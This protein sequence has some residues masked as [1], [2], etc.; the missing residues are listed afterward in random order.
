MTSTDDLPATGVLRSTLSSRNLPIWGSRAQMYERLKKGHETTKL[1]SK[2]G[3]TTTLTSDTTN[4]S[5]VPKPAFEP[6]ERTFY[7]QERPKLLARGITDHVALVA[8]LKRLWVAK[9]TSNPRSKKQP[10]HHRKQISKA[11]AKETSTRMFKSFVCMSGVDMAVA[12]C[13]LIGVET[14]SG[15]NQYVYENQ[16]QASS[17]VVLL[18][19]PTNKKRRKDES[20]DDDSSSCETDDSEME[21]D[22]NTTAHRRRKLA[23]RFRKMP[24][25]L[26]KENLKWFQ[27]KVNGSRKV[28]LERFARFATRES[29]S[30]Y[31]SSESD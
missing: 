15:K 10:L 24:K 2:P 27:A 18:T 22:D 29:D 1:G 20:S 16:S 19:T 26:L 28:L 21:C 3:Q 12:G 23:H 30:E 17:N 11:S 7:N 14:S 13:T 8:E 6:G 5:A 9:K 4:P 25:D 31:S